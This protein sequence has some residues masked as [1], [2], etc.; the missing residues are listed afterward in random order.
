MYIRSSRDF[1][2]GDRLTER[3][4]L[5]QM[6]NVVSRTKEMRSEKTSTGV[7]IKKKKDFDPSVM[8]LHHAA[9]KRLC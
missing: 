9:L 5:E 2:Q 4:L 6:S 8:G 3:S 7:E 1:D